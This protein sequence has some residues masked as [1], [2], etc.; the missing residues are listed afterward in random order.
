[1]N[2]T[3]ASYSSEMY[4][5]L[6]KITFDKNKVDYA[7]KH[8]YKSKFYLTESLDY[9]HD[10]LKIPYGFARIEFILELLKND[11]EWI[12]IS[13]SD[14]IVT[15]DTI[16]IE[17]IVKDYN[18][19]DLLCTFDVS[20][21]NADS[22]LIRN[23]Q[24]SKEYFKMIYDMRFS[25]VPDEQNAIIKTYLDHP[26]IK[27]IPQ[28]LIN[29]YDHALIKHT[30]NHVGQYEKG[31]FAIHFVNMGLEDRIKIVNKYLNI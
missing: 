29:S 5:P 20:H 23:T 24:W 13:G 31:D 10:V 26:Q 9:Y 17:D 2:V 30:T 4:L 22:L 11:T 25:G 7:N 12:W 18:G 14:V 15:N 19:Y 21:I 16:K 1:M 28:R 3:I 8:G 27:I 6:S